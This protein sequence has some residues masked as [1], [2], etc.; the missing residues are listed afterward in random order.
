[1]AKWE[2][3]LLFGNLGGGLM[4]NTLFPITKP[5]VFGN[6]G[7]GQMGNDLFSS[8]KHF[9]FKY[10]TLLFPITLHDSTLPGGNFAHQKNTKRAFR[11][12]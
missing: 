9:V 1:M 4:E 11:N 10:K 5:F 6:L 7:Y 3:L 2:T 12:P 8:T